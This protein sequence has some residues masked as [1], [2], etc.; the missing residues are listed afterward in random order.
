MKYYTRAKFA[1]RPKAIL[2]D[3][4]NTVYPYEPA[5]K[6]AS[7]LVQDKVTS[8]YMISKD[9]F[10]EANREAKTQIKKQ[11]GHTASSHSRLLYF[12]RTLELLGLSA[13]LLSALDLEQTYWRSFL[14][15]AK[16]FDNVIET[17]NEI[18]LHGI[19]LVCVTDL[20]AQIQMRKIIHF[21]LD[22]FIDYLVTSEESGADKFH[23]ASYE[24]A[25]TKLGLCDGPCWMVGDNPETDIVGARDAIDAVT[26]QKLH[27]GVK[28]SKEATPDASFNDFRE[29]L[30][31]IT[32]IGNT[33]GISN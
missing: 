32:T 26:I 1:L 7:Q 22:K 15:E 3:L 11:L 12:Q 21:G 25:L 17:F 16:L 28:R 31:L 27:K 13:Q 14:L 5:H 29:L 23:S 10:L 8:A 30:T 2:F 20:T 4:D 18:R 19:P 6:K 24:L 9:N 33:K